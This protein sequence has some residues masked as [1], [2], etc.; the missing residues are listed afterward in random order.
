MVPFFS[1][2]DVSGVSL[3]KP[4]MAVTGVFVME[5]WA[6]EK[7]GW[8]VPVNQLETRNGE[9]KKILKGNLFNEVQLG[10]RMN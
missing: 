1:P 9:G 2:C 5:A 7:L 6:S 3:K 10:G 8:L 4:L